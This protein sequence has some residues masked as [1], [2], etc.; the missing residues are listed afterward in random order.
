[1]PKGN[2]DNL[3][4]NE[5]LTPE[6]RRENARKAGIAS[7]QARKE[8]KLLSQIYAE[9]LADEYEAKID[10]VSVKITGEKLVK[11]VARDIL[12]RKDSSSVS[13]IKEIREAT[14]GNKVLVG[15]TILTSSLSEEAIEGIS[16]EAKAELALAYAR[17]L[18]M[19]KNEPDDSGPSKDS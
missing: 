18:E 3:I 2:I 9:M 10:G 7:G 4:K 5:D 12:M 17:G 16:P 11:T 6:E 19:G 8:K 15:G 13:M 1:M 14:E